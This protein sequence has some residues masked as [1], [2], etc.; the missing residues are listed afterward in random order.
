M[1]PSGAKQTLITKVQIKNAES[2]TRN[3]QAVSSAETETTI[4]DE[5]STVASAAVIKEI[6]AQVKRTEAAAQDA[7]VKCLLSSWYWP[8]V[9][10]AHEGNERDGSGYG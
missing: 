4:A 1:M 6:M 8:R 3:K 5:A 7:G 10:P 9:Y 2:E